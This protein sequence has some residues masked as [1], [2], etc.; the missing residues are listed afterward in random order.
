MAHGDARK[1]KWRGNWRMEWVASTLTLPRN[2]VYPALLPLMRTPRLPAFD[3]TDA[4]ANV[5]GLVRFG[6]RGNLVPARVPSRFKRTLPRTMLFLVTKQQFGKSQWQI[7][8]PWQMLQDRRETMLIAKS[9][10][11]QIRDWWLTEVKEILKTLLTYLGT[12]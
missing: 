9:T 1:G 4:P 11:S 12:G 2:V 10:N 7:P 3:W 6:E 5:N 8:Q